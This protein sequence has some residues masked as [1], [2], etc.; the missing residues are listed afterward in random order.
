MISQIIHYKNFDCY[1]YMLC[2]LDTTICTVS[3]MNA[4]PKRLSK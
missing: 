1:V 4:I 2:D 3:D